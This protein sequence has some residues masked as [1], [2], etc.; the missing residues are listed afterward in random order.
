[1]RIRN[2]WLTSI[3]SLSCVWAIGCSDDTTIIT[4]IGDVDASVSS[5]DSLTTYPST[6]TD[7]STTDSVTFPPI[8]VPTLDPSLDAGI[9][10]DLP[11][12][13]WTDS[14]DITTD[15]DVDASLPSDDSTSTDTDATSTDPTNTSDDAG[16]AFEGDASVFVPDGGAVLRPEELSF[17][18]SFLN[19][20]TVPNGFSLNVFATPG[21]K[22]R[23]LAERDGAIYVTRPEQG[24]VLRLQDTNADGEADQQ[25]TPIS[26]YPGIHG[27]T[28]HEDDVYLATATELIRATVAGDGSFTSPEVLLNDL[29]DGGQH[30][31][32]TLGVGPDGQLYLSLGS[33]CDACPEANP[34][35][36]TI[37]RVALDGTSRTVFARGLR[38]TIGFGWQPET[39]QLWGMDHGSDWRGNDIPPEELNLIEEGNDYGWPYCYGNAVVDPIIQNPPGQDKPSYCANTTAAVLEHQ[40]HEAPIGLVFYAGTAFPSEYY[41]DAFIAMRGSWNRVPAT[42]YKI[43]RLVFEDGQP[44]RFEDFVTGFLNPAGTATF[45]RPAGI[46]VDTFGGLVFT[47]DSNGVIY[48]VTYSD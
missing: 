3:T 32:R 41:G 35:H 20:L 42:G 7:T 47:D 21:G 26:G 11:D 46:T 48:R 6:D 37:L 13:A 9:D 16:V 31:L 19:Q 22:T 4:P 36:A 39:N 18:P 45:A 10:T 8:D 23:M 40:A 27:I 1:M 43:V 24:D 17:D 12:A 25:S 44:T 2:H 28:F 15:L 5:S 29:P 30:P 38:N 14:T 33:S 34:E